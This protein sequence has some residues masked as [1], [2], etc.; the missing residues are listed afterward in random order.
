M[1]WVNEEAFRIQTIQRSRDPEIQNQKRISYASAVHS[2]SVAFG[3]LVST[4]E[5]VEG[6]PDAVLKRLRLPGT[7]ARLDLPEGPALRIRC[8][9]VAILARSGTITACVETDQRP[10]RIAQAVGFDGGP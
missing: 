4:T 2:A 5:A 9:P 7:P 3:Q 6:S 8:Q 10:R 1:R